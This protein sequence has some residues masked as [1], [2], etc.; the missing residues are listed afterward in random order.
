MSEIDDAPPQLSAETLK[1]LQEFLQEQKLNQNDNEKV[2]ENWQL[3]QFWYDDDTTHTLSNAAISLCN[4]YGNVAL[5]S[6]P[7]LYPT[8][9]SIITHRKLNVNIKL[10]EFDKRFSKYGDDFIFYDY[11]DPH[12]IK[13]NYVNSFDVVIVDPPFLSEECLTKTIQTINRLKKS[14]CKIILCTGQIME[15]L[16]N[17]LL[18]L[19]RCLFQPK[20]KNNLANE[21]ICLTNFGELPP[22]PPPPSPTP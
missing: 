13:Q 15:Q 14:N 22:P 4:E 2:T 6:C 16:A 21:F 10:L 17:K 18:N 8:I 5:I 9:K 12:N 19:N 1:A 11:N 20:H 7:T 3:S